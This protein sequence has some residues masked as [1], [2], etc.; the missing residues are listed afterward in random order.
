MVE[1]LEIKQKVFDLIEKHRTAGTIVTSNTS[2]IPI[3]LMSK[4]RSDDFNKNFAITHFFNPPRY[5]DL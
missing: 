1:K 3:K 5:L 2:G 4:G